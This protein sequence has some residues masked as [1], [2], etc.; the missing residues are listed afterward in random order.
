[1]V[2]SRHLLMVTTRHLIVVISRHLV[3]VT[4]R[5]L[6]PIAASVGVRSCSAV[7][8]LLDA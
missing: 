2:T 6:S 3:V 1:M 5:A 7:I 4:S 8:N